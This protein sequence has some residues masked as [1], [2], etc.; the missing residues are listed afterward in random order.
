MWHTHIYTHH[1]RRGVNTNGADFAMCNVTV[2][3]CEHVHL[4]IVRAF[5][6]RRKR[7]HHW[8]QWAQPR[9]LPRNKWSCSALQCVGV[10]SQSH[11]EAARQ[12]LRR[13]K[14]NCSVLQCRVITGSS[15]PRF[16]WRNEWS[17]SAWQCV[18]V[19]SSVLQ[20]AAVCGGV[21]QCAAVFGSVL[22]CVAVCCMAVRS[23]S[24]LAAAGAASIPVT[25]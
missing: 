13:N 7:N 6:R 8:R 2:F 9:F 18:A 17:C 25:K 1:L 12:F 16:L 21:L 19:C 3:R 5:D 4:R 11:L 20:C 22:Q 10:W 14:W 23:Q 24:A 15:G